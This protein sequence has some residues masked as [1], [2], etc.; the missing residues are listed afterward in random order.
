MVESGTFRY[1]DTANL[2]MKNNVLCKLCQFKNYLCVY[3]FPRMA[4]GIARLVT[5]MFCRSQY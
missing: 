5:A 1:Y 2:L 3:V 4:Y